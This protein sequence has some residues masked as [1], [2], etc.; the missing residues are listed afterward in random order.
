[1][2]E[3]SMMPEDI[4]NISVKEL[5]PGMV[6][7]KDL[8]SNDTFLL[9]QGSIL[10]ENVIDKL[11]GIYLQDNVQ[12][13]IPEEIMGE[14]RREMEM[15]KVAQAFQQVESKL[16]KLFTKMETLDQNSISDLKD[17]ASKVQ[18]QLNHIELALSKVLFRGDEGDCIYKHG[19]NVAILSA[20]LGKW[21]GLGTKKVNMLI[22]AAMLHD[23]GITK[24]SSD[25][26]AEPDLTLVDK[27][28]KVKEHVKIAY[29]CL[30]IIK[31]LDQSVICGVLMHHERCD[32]SGY[33]LGLTEDKIP[34]FAKIIAIADEFDVL[35]SNKELM[36]K[37]GMFYS[38]KMIKEKSL[39]SLD[40]Q[41]SKVFLDHISN[42]FIGEDVRLSNGDTAKVLQMNIENLENPLLLK[43][44]EFIDM[45]KNKD[46]FVKELVIK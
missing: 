6:L 5:L 11:N 41:Y 40:Y 22:Y 3:I 10:D 21:L 46:L 31:N 16:K 27:N 17:F 8:I 2:E 29:D 25:F 4:F 30:K 43:D 9:K 15:R 37:Y 44:N 18:E 28:F 45:K 24:L 19:V 32:G 26:Q 36:N 13:Y 20:L 35:N 7:S 23:F 12:V 38:L 1:M 39:K 33:P 42:F 14:R 34:D